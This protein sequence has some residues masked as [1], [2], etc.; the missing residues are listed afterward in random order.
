MG[1]LLPLQGSACLGSVLFVLDFLHMGFFAFL[2]AFGRGD[3][4][5]SVLGLTR[6]E[7]V[8]S[9]PVVD[10]THLGSLTLLRGPAYMG[11]APLALDFLHLELL[12]SLQ[13]FGQTGSP[14]SLAGVARLD[15]SLFVLDAVTMASS[16]SLRSPAR[17]DLVLLVLDLGHLEFLLSIRS[18][19][20]CDLMMPAFSQT[21]LGFLALA[22]DFAHFDFL[23]FLQSFS[24]PDL[25]V[26]ALDFLRMEPLLFFRSFGCAEPLLS[27]FGTA[28]T[29][30]SLLVLDFLHL[31]LS[32]LPR[33][34]AHLGPVVLVLDL[35]KLGFPSS[36][37]SHARM[38][39]IASTLGL[40]RTGS[41]FSLSVIS[42]AHLELL[43]LTQALGCLELVVFVLDFLRSDSSSSVRS[44]ARFGLAFSV[45]GRLQLGSSLLV[46][47]HAM[48]GFPTSIRSFARSGSALSVFDFLHL[49]PLPSAQSFDHLE[50]TFPVSCVTCLSSL[51]L[52]LDLASMG[53]LM[54]LHSLAQLDFLLSALNFVA[55]GST[56][57]SRS[58]ACTGSAMSIS[59]LSCLELVFSL[60]LIDNTHLDS[61]LLVRGCA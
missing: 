45:C 12:P 31:G 35:L 38:D 39:S 34:S 17:S 18:M 23:P 41:V 55:A 13:S 43:L 29:G 11:L 61:L 7:F 51:L 42:S 21:R 44:S 50:L 26:F 5:L 37:R 46:L 28:C 24:K 30:S 48:L 10:Y 25:V 49:A 57:L 16:L 54:L 6:L 36:M 53:L 4:M 40:T 15:P 33:Q 9:L 14:L 19:A 56:M 32:L 52:L 60:F 47:E 22:L 3:P 20:R 27:A 1:F 58:V 2:Q 59:G 8:S